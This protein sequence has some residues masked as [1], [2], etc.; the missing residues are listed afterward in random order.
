LP[1]IC[2]ARPRQISGPSFVANNSPDAPATATRAHH[3]WRGAL[4]GRRVRANPRKAK[5][6]G[7]IDAGVALASG[8]PE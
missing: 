7:A 4:I 5:W 3:A 1:S 2:R 6:T 8:W